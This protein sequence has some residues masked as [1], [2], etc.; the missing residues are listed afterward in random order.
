MKLI[1][2]PILSLLTAASAVIAQSPP[3]QPA[4][5][6]LKPAADVVDRAALEA[7]RVKHAQCLPRALDWFQKNQNPDG[8]WGD[9][10]KS[11]MT[12]LA[13]LS[14]LAHG[15]TPDSWTY[16][17]SVTKAV[18]WII[19]NGAKFDGRMH[20]AQQF[21]ASGVYEHGICTYALCEYYTMTKDDRVLPMLKKAVGYIVEGQG[22]GGGWMYTY[23]KSAND[24][25]VSGWQIQALKAA[26]L[27]KLNLPGVEASLD[28]AVAYI[29]HVK[30][31]K[32]GY[33]YR[34][35]GDKYSLTGVG[36]YSSLLWKV[37][38]GELRKGME[39]LIDETE[40]NKPVKYNSDTADLYAWYYHTR[41]C[42]MFGGSA[43]KR[44]NAWFQDEIVNAQ[45]ADGSWPV[46]S[47]KGHGPQSTPD[48]TGQ[49]YR[50]ALCTLML[51]AFYRYL[52]TLEE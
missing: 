4:R 42:L 1:A 17:P 51:E 16:G 20:M 44:W 48:K 6:L 29:E 8:S 49:V 2:I 21:N 10:N 7:L 41:A 32:G 11:A 9:S 26:H 52:P 33:G 39:W 24:L 22:P 50:T 19:E 45:G 43:W 14:F 23:D 28:K 27:T 18:N 35:A 3:V 12:G 38:R 46:P 34:E 5:P 36:I 15:E 30:G 31:P 25:S 13:L 40:K 37:E 47:V